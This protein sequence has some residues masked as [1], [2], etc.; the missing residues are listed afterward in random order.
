MRQYALKKEDQ[1]YHVL[2]NQIFKILPLYEEKHYDIAKHIQSTILEL[3]G[4]ENVFFEFHR[5]PEFFRL[6][7]TLNSLGSL[8]F[9]PSFD[10]ETVKKIHP[11]VKREVFKCLS[12]IKKIDGDQS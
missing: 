11:I 7:G 6:M 4:L 5:N 12:I 1:Y 10:K 2:T 3:D 9:S 8:L